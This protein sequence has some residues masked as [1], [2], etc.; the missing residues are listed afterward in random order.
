[1]EKS[2]EE[3]LVLT[4]SSTG[5]ATQILPSTVSWYVLHW[6]PIHLGGSSAETNE[7]AHTLET[8]SVSYDVICYDIYDHNYGDKYD[9]LVWYIM[10]IIMV[11]IM[12]ILAWYNTIIHM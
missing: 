11:I 7:V 6:H 1:M 12:T 8:A 4:T 10:T 2:T 3:T 5:F 9:H